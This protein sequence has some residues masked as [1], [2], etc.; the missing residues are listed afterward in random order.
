MASNAPGIQGPIFARIS[1]TLPVPLCFNSKTLIINPY[2]TGNNKFITD[3]PGQTS[4]TYSPN[5]KYLYTA[6]TS[7]IIRKFTTTSKDEPVTIETS[8]ENTALAATV[9][10]I[11]S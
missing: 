2:V 6:G 7:S 3:P 8:T 9:G 4:L 10:K 5:G 11:F 1:S